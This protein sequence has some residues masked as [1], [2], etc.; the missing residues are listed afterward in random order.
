MIK[1]LVLLIAVAGV[2]TAQDCPVRVLHV[3]KS[4]IQPGGS[5]LNLSLQSTSDK[6]VKDADFAVMILDSA[7]EPH[8]LM[9][10]FESGKIKAGTKKLKRYSIGREVLDPF[11]RVKFQAWPHTVQ[12]ADGTSWKDDGTHSCS[13]ET[14]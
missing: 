8:A 2:L 4:Q 11:T 13:M 3:Y 10:S 9:G 6:E 1:N 5:L 7:G 12:F 14:K